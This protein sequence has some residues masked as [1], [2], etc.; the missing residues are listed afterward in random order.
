MWGAYLCIRKGER[1]GQREPFQETLKEFFDILRNQYK[2]EP[3]VE[4]GMRRTR[5]GREK[6]ERWV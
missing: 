1:T 3:P 5:E 6:D 2:Y 4:M